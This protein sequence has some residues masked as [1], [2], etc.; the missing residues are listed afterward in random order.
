MT[1]VPKKI[2]LERL[3]KILALSN[4]S[5]DH[6]AL[7][8]ARKA[9]KILQDADL[10]YQ[11][12]FSDYIPTQPNSGTIGGDDASR[13]VAQLRREIASLQAS[14]GRTRTAC[15][16]ELYRWR[17]QLLDEKPLM[18]SERQALSEMQSI[19]PKSKEEFYVRWLV[20]RY[21]LAD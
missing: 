2:D 14:V 6:E 8:A 13:L 21:Q 17:K 19:P 20:R 1:A 11:Q 7:A 10:T 15:A 9:A 16:P 12:L 4:S 5:F 3:A 18:A